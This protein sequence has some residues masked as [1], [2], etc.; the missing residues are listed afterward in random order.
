M[1]RQKRDNPKKG[2]VLHV[3]A[4]LN[5][6]LLALPDR[7]FSSFVFCYCPCHYWKHEDVLWPN[8]DV[9]VVQDSRVKAITFMVQFAC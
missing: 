8:Q 9:Q 3:V 5:C 6:S 2:Y 4:T 1:E 7:F